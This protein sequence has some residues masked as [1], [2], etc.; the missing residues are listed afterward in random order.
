MRVQLNNSRGIAYRRLTE[1]LAQDRL[2]EYL[3][4]NPASLARRPRHHT[5]LEQMDRNMRRARLGWPG[6]GVTPLQDGTAPERE[7]RVAQYRMPW[8]FKL[9]ILVGRLYWRAHCKIAWNLWWRWRQ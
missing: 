3:A 2:T 1:V 6:Y 8:H 9:R 4:S 5:R 7:W